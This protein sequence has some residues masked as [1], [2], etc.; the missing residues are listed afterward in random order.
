MKK[1]Y[2]PE[3]RRTIAAVCGNVSKIQFTTVGHLN[4]GVPPVC[5]SFFTGGANSVSVAVLTASTSKFQHLLAVQDI[6]F[7]K[8]SSRITAVIIYL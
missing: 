3:I 2:P 6:D 4:L 5:S 1:I 7:E 8:E